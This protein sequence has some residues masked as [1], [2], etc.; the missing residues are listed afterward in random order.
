MH[1]RGV[2]FQN[3]AP[4]YVYK[5]FLRPSEMNFTFEDVNCSVRLYNSHLGTKIIARP[6]AKNLA[7]FPSLVYI[8]HR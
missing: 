4:R 2:R 5:S 8:L 7:A 1:E 6:L 3:L